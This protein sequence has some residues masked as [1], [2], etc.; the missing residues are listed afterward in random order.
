VAFNHQ[1]AENIFSPHFSEIHISRLSSVSLQVAVTTVL[2]FLFHRLS[3]LPSIRTNSSALEAPLCLD[4]RTS[5]QCVAIDS[6]SQWTKVPSWVLTLAF[7]WKLSIRPLSFKEVE[8][9]QTIWHL[10]TH[11]K[12]KKSEEVN[13]AY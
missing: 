5:C 6:T 13:I 8:A 12:G 9:D 11:T 7:K 10:F 3:N 2:S 4:C 1:S